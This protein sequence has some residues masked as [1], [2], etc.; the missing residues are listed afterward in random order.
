[1]LLGVGFEVSKAYTS[2]SLSISVSGGLACKGL[3][4]G[5]HDMPVGF[6]PMMIMNQLS[7]S[8]TKLDFSAAIEY[9]NL[10]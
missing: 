5:S 10:T 4:L 6:P 8:V 1:M 3:S 2:L 7:K 9:H